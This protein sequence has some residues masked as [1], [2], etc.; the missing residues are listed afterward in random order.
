MAEYREIVIRLKK[1]QSIRGIHKETGMHRTIIRKIKQYATDNGW[2]H[3]DSQI[4]TEETL[5]NIWGRLATPNAHPLD[6]WQDKIEAWL[7]DKYSYVVIHQLIY[8]DFQCSEATVRRYIQKEFPAYH[9]VVMCRDTIAGEI[10]EVDYGY[11]GITHDHLTDKKRK[12]YIFSGRLRHS[13]DAYREIV[14]D[15]KQDTFFSCHMNAFEHF[16]G[17]PEK[18]VPDNLK[19]AV[20]RASYENPII[21]RVYRALAEHY[22]FMISPNLPGRPEHKGGVENDIK[23]VK[24]NFWPI[25]KE[26][27]KAKGYAMPEATELKDALAAWNIN[28]ARVR[29]VSGVGRTPLDIFESE[30][31]AMLQPLPPN[32]WMPLEWGEGIK[33]Q[34]NCRIQFD[35]AFYSVPYKHVGKLVDVLANRITVYVFLSHE[36][37]AMHSRAKK[38]WEIVKK[39]EHFPPHAEEYMRTTR[40]SLKTFAAEIGQ[41]T[42]KV[43]SQ[44]LDQK[45]VDGLRPARAILFSLKKKYG[46]ERLEAACERAWVYDTP[47]YFSV[48]SILLKDLDKLT[49]EQPVDAQGQQLFH[50]AREQGYFDPTGASKAEGGKSWMN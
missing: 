44:I 42:G 43:V 16:G 11:L 12:T 40:E 2:L 27:Q 7:K 22:N 38:K 48:K 46:T 15:Q 29:K 36:Q 4:P 34:D 9:K 14:F 5:Y 20:I 37:V 10:M 28:T 39:S 47:E 45:H 25:F 30:E 18:V 50:F 3:P 41:Y 19:A 1:S 49:V 13:R 17:V 35:C 24:N 23:Y 32:K 8:P 33:V 26:Q 31:K 21:N 6:K